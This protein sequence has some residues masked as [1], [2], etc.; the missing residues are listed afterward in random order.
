ML[1]GKQ[2]T[3]RLVFALHSS[4][5]KPNQWKV[6]LKISTKTI[7]SWKNWGENR[8]EWREKG[9]WMD[10]IEYFPS[11]S[12]KYIN[13]HSLYFL[14]IY[15]ITVLPS[16]LPINILQWQNR[17]TWYFK[18]WPG[19]VKPAHVR[20]DSISTGAI[21]QGTWMGNDFFTGNLHG[22]AVCVRLILQL[23]FLSELE[24]TNIPCWWE[25]PQE[26][27]DPILPSLLW[28]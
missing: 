3:H 9:R 21:G 1:K 24:W 17:N 23:T 16:L 25:R 18:A 15:T 10:R 11:S 13:L 14:C 6:F 26:M 2:T 7:G 5:A 20:A 27:L 4:V 22:T 28:V 8:K 12:Q 19:V